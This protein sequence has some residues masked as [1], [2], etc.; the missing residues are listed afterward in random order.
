MESVT[1]AAW[2]MRWRHFLINSLAFALCYPLANLLAQRQNI[3]RHIAFSFESTIPFL[4]WM[5]IPYLSS[6]IF[7][8]L[9]FAWMRGKD[10]LRVLSQR[11]LLATIS[12]SLIFSLYPLQFSMQK[13]AIDAPLFSTLF[14]FLSLVDRP[15]NQLPS[16]HVAFCVIIWQSLQGSFKSLPARG[17]LTIWLALVALATV[18]TY[19]HHLLDIVTGFLLGLCAILLVRRN[20]AQTN[21]AFHYLMGAGIVLLVGVFAMHSLAAV[22]LMLSLLLVG[23]AYLREDRYFLHKNGGRFPLWTWLLYAPYLLGYRLTWCYVRFRERRRPPFVQVTEWLWVGRRLTR[24]EAGHL[25]E[26][27]VVIDLANELSETSSLRSHAYWHFPLLDLL[28]PDPAAIA[29][30]VGLMIRETGNGRPV[31]L[32]CAMGYS[33]STFIAKRYLEKIGK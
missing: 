8:A 5:I 4:P 10:D 11:M 26:H 15:Y 31:Y 33:R 17:A 1:H 13:P 30:I 14:N 16:L 21:V 6:G 7:F 3:T 23:L 12:A 27:C 20:R 2:S 18:F 22:Y 32:H 28:A 24:G 29:V 25:P 9:S 19:Q